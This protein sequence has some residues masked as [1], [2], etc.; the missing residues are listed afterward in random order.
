MYIIIQRGSRR[1][2]NDSS[3]PSMRLSSI[4]VPIRYKYCDVYRVLVLYI[5][6]R[7]AFSGENLLTCRHK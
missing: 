6:I 2:Y 4:F 5:I 3:R 1:D 7:Y